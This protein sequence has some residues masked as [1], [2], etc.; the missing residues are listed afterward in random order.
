[1]NSAE[2]DPHSD[3]RRDAR[4]DIVLELQYRNEGHLLVSY[5]TN[6]SRGGLFVP[7]SDPWPPGTPVQVRLSLPGEPVALPIAAEVRW[8][9]YHEDREG[10]PGMGLRFQAIDRFLGER[11]DHIVSDFRPQRVVVASNNVAVRSHV[12]AQVRVL[13]RCETDLRSID[14]A[15]VRELATADLVI[16]DL[17]HAG[18]EGVTLLEAMVGLPVPPPWVVLGERQPAAV[19]ERAHLLRRFV[20]TPVDPH[21]LRSAVLEALAHVRAQRG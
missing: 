16:V 17:D 8:T 5:C 4:A 14:P 1:M 10:P 19:R 21:E 6:L 2:D 11:I 9:R 15:I 18:N 12:A 13:V 7:C 3:S 20:Y